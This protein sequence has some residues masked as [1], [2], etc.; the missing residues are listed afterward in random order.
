MR[1]QNTAEIAFARMITTPRPRRQCALG[2]S[3]HPMIICAQTYTRNREQSRYEIQERMTE[4]SPP[5]LLLLR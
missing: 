5:P 3:A 1:T 2:D 4:E